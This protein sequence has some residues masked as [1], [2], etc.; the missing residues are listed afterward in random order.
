MIQP[1]L[2]SYTFQGGPI[3]VI[4]DVTSVKPDGILLLD[5]FFHIVIFHGSTIAQ[6]REAKYQDLPEHVAF[7][8]LLELP[9]IHAQDIINSRFPVPRYILCDQGK[10]QSRFL[11]ARLNPSSKNAYKFI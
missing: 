9:Q 6:W 2:L 3:P 4:L 10:S 8:Q 1:A 7:K 5:T 11:M